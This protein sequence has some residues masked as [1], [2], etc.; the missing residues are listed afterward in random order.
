[1]NWRTIIGIILSLTSVE[2][3]VSMFVDYA[4][5]KSETVPFYVWIALFT[6]A[7]IGFV[8][9]AKGAQKS[10]KQ[11]QQLLRKEQNAQESADWRN[12]SLINKQK[13]DT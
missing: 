2:K 1:M 13:L 6:V 12:E 10:V 7:I 5:N 4:A 11:K 8:L 3:L 9:I